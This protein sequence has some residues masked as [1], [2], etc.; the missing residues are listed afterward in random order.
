M[1]SHISTSAQFAF[2]VCKFVSLIVDRLG[3]EQCS[4]Y[5]TQEVE[6]EYVV[7]SNSVDI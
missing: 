6:L 2:G 3:R 4:K 5:V 1:C 7:L